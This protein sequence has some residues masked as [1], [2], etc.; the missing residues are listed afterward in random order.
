MAT[1]SADNANRLAW[2]AVR[3]R[4]DEDR[5]ARAGSDEDR[6]VRS[7]AVRSASVI[8]GGGAA[9]IVVMPPA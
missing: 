8:F 1:P 2:R 6:P 5:A 4:N 7:R 3:C 9:S